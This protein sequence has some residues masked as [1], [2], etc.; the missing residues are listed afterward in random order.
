[1][2]T[3]ITTTCTNMPHFSSTTHDHVTDPELSSKED[4]KTT[5]EH[6]TRI[7]AK[8]RRKRYLDTTPSYFTSSSLELADPLLYD[9]LVRRFQ[10]AAE[11]EQLGRERGYTGNLEADL[12]RSEAK[13]EALQRPDPYVSISYRREENGEIVEVEKGEEVGGREEGW[14]RW[15]DVMGQRFLKGDDQDFDYATVDKNEEFDDRTEEDRKELEGYLDEEEA[16]F[17]GEGKPQGETGVQ[18]F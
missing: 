9:R 6:A 17:V 5:D 1:M 18:D 11:R 14:A 10:T 13:L 7:K 3:T 16:E 12:L 2:R 4:A 15:T 8:N